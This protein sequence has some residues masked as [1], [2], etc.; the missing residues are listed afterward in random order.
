[1]LGSWFVVTISSKINE[2]KL[3]VH[4]TSLQLHRSSTEAY[5]SATCDKP[6]QNNTT[7]KKIVLHS[8]RK[9]L[10]THLW[11]RVAWI[12]KNSSRRSRE[13]RGSSNQGFC[14]GFHQIKPMVGFVAMRWVR[15]WYFWCRSAWDGGGSLGC[16]EKNAIEEKEPR[17]SEGRVVSVRYLPTKKIYHTQE[18]NRIFFHIGNW[19]FPK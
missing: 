16:R 15:W 18:D 7:R 3:E 19:Y 5:S 13:H 12:D 9:E 10:E 6:H 17:G 2:I 4:Q 14:S 11:T 8:T 1:M